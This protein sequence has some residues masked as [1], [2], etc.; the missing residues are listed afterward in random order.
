MKHNNLTALLCTIFISIGFSQVFASDVSLAWD[1]VA[2]SALAGYKLY[3]GTASGNY[4]API[5]VGNQT[6]YTVSG[7]QS[8]TTYYFAVTAYDGMLKETTY[9]AEVSTQTPQPAPV[10]S[11][12]QNTIL[13]SNSATITWNTNLASDS[14]IDYGLTTTYGQSAANASMVQTHTLSLNNLSANTQYHYRVKSKT[15]AGVQT[16]SGDFTLTTLAPMDSTGPVISNIAGSTTSASATISWTT[17]EAAT[18]QIDYGTSTSYGSS[19]IDA[20]LATAHTRFLSGLQSNTQY[21]YRIT[22][23]DAAGNA[24]TSADLTFTTQAAPGGDT[25]PPVISAVACSSITYSAATISWTTNEASTTQVEYGASTSYGKTASGV[26][27]LITGHSLQLTGLQP[28]TTYHYRV[29]STDAAGN[30]A[31]SGDFTFRT[32]KRNG[33]WK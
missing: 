5:T 9:S 24:S 27:N 12:V 30:I 4:G 23:K 28:N 15:S 16:A 22:S 21:H 6:A 33:R 1:P 7:L 29:V 25:T 31:R 20:T 8:G 26:A 17:N 13:T 2:S 32:A 18:T 14:Q 3:Y 11:N 10:L 19:S